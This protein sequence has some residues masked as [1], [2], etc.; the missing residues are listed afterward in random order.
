V[1]RVAYLNTEYPSLSHTFIEREIRVVREQGVEVHPFSIRRAGKHARLSQA[2]LA[3]ANETQPILGSPWALIRDAAA[4]IV[5]HPIGCLRA[6]AASQRLACP[7]L[8]TRV[9]HLAYTLEA[10]RLT[11]LLERRG[12]KHIHVHMANNGAAVAQLA[13]KVDPS[14]SYSLS[15]HGSAEFFHVDSWALK[16]KAQGAVF[17]R[18]ISDFCRAQVMAWT[19][20]SAWQR[21]HVVR[22]GVDPA[23]YR[24]TGG[25]PAPG[26]RLLTVGRLHPIKG[27]PLLL[28]ACAELSARG[29]DWSLDM[30]GDGPMR[31]ELEALA[32]RLGISSRITFSGAVGQDK[33]REHYERATVMVVS[34]FMEGVPVVLMEAMAMEMPVLATAVGGIPELIAPGK[35]GELVTP[36]SVP[37]LVDG[38]LRLASRNGELKAMGAAARRTVLDDYNIRT[39]GREMGGLFRR[40]LP[41]AQP[42]ADRVPELA[43]AI[44]MR[45]Y[46]ALAVLAMCF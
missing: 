7:G 26:L 43:G 8:R 10:M 30:V 13:T 17:V 1:I 39:G 18:C 35:N 12:L 20:P 38:L 42:Q 16:A 33:I 41:E 19:D 4:A 37:A 24:R 32:R 27:Y 28:E 46:S 23:R 6:A 25:E 34:S 11:R 2:H 14:L 15:I 22:C 21:M 36:G 44:A 9:K 40:Y 45:A 3:A 5:L 31:A 29:V